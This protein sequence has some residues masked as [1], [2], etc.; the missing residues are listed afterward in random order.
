M[1]R[2][3]GDPHT[4]L[5]KRATELNLPPSVLEKAGQVYNTAKTL[6]H[7]DK[8]EDLEKRGS[9]FTTLDVPAMVESY[10]EFAP[11][12]TTKPD[13][14]DL[15]SL[16][17]TVKSAGDKT[18]N[19]YE[20]PDEFNP[21]CH[22]KQDLTEK[23]ASATPVN[24]FDLPSD[25]HIKQARAKKLAAERDLDSMRTVKSAL[26]QALRSK[27]ASFAE[28]YTGFYCDAPELN[29][30]ESECTRLFTGQEQLCKRAFDVVSKFIE[31]VPAAAGRVK[32][33]SDSSESKG[34][35]QKTSFHESI[36][37]IMDQIEMCDAAAEEYAEM[38]KSAVEYDSK[39]K[40]PP[41]PRSTEVEQ[42]D[43][44]KHPGSDAETIDPEI[45][46]DEFEVTDDDVPDGAKDVSPKD[47]KEKDDDSDDDSDDD[48]DK[49]EDKPK[50][51]VVTVEKGVEKE[52]P[53]AKG[54]G[55]DVVKALR[56]AKDLAVEQGSKGLGVLKDVRQHATDERQADIDRSAMLARGE[57][58]L[59]TLLLTD[60]VIGEYDEENMRDIFFTIFASNPEVATDINQLRGVLRT[61][62][63]FEGVVD[64]DTVKTLKSLDKPDKDKS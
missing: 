57:A 60:P 4:A 40:Q 34:L 38:E 26:Q 25:A 23:A 7:L 6:N 37:S 15:W 59:N 22:D 16:A 44:D 3:S 17:V 29:K 20:L 39:K 55:L 27:A 64:L 8:A 63:N 58:A 61:A 41:V 1:I 56:K 19:E 10:K 12:T 53:T 52:A 14:T 5:I 13:P 51:E 2:E 18:H 32:R 11:D 54:T 35:I 43:P 36:E 50:A 47:D 9:T 49:K 24:S 30:L 31:T 45:V 62:G 33:S 28:S 21:L 42:A 48:K 46:D